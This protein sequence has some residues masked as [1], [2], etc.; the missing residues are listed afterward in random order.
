MEVE[1]RHESVDVESASAMF[2]GGAVLLD[3]R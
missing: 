2:G 3:V 1:R